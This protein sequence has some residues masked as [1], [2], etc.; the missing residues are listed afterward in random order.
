MSRDNCRNNF[1][2]SLCLDLA[3]TEETRAN[4]KEKA[5]A[6]TRRVEIRVSSGT[7]VFP[8]QGLVE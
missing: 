7:R 2:P 6:E 1:V 5:R 4:D 8:V 3:I